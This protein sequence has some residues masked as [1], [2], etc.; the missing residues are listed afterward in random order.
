ME[1]SSDATPGLTCAGPRML[2]ACRL[3]WALVHSPLKNHQQRGLEVCRHK[4]ATNPPDKKEL[5]YFEDGAW[6]MHALCSHAC[7]LLGLHA[8]RSSYHHGA[9]T[10]LGTL[11]VASI[12]L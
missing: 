1:R 11:R 5:R 3:I 9:R 2:P 7:T 12:G 6:C 10:T 8:C 4:L